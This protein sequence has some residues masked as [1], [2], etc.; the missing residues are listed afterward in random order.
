MDGTG[1]M[2]TPLRVLVLEGRAAD[3]ELAVAELRWAG[4]APEWQRVETEEDY[5]AALGPELDVILSDYSLTGFDAPRALE[6][7]Q[8]KGLD[9]PFIAV[10][11]VVDED[12]A[13]ALMREGAADYLLK[14]RL[15]RLGQAVGHALEERRLREAE[16]RTE[17]DLRA[18]DERFRRLAEHA[19]DMIYRYRVVPPRGFEYVS[20]AATAITD[21][22]AQ[23][24]Y[25]DPDLI[26]KLVHPDD[27]HL[28]EAVLAGEI[29]EKP[30]ALRW[31]RTDGAVVWTEQRDVPVRDE[32]GNLVAVEGI[33][34][35]ITE[36]VLR[37]QELRAVATMS[38]ALRVAPGRAEM[39]PVILGEVMAL[40][41]A[42]GAAL[43]LRDPESGETVVE[44]AVGEWSQMAGLRLAAG[45]GVVGHVI[46][47]GQPHI[48][49][50]LAAD[51]RHHRLPPVG[52][53][54]A[55][56][57]LPLLAQKETVGALGAGRR[58]PF[59]DHEV[60]VL[61]AIADIAASAIR[62]ATQH[63]E[64]QRRLQRLTSLHTIDLAISK[65]LNLR[66]TLHT[67]LVQVTT[68]LAVDAASVLLLDSKTQT[69]RRT[70][71]R[72]FRTRRL[73]VRSLSIPRKSFAGRAALERRIVLVPDL[74]QARGEFAHPERLAAEGFVGCAAVPL[75]TRD[76][77][78][79]VLTIYRRAPLAPDREWLGFLEALSQQAAIAIDNAQLFDE[80]QRSQAELVTAY[81]ATLEG[82]ARA[83][84]L[85]NFETAGHSNRVTELTVR[86]GRALRM[87]EA[88]LAEARRGALLHDI[89]KMAIPD[90]IL[91]K[92][93][94][95]TPDEWEIMR[96][97]PTHAFELLSPITFLRPAAEIA[98]SHHEKWDGTGYP[99]GLKGEE[100]PLGA[101]AF[102]VCDV[103]DA[104]L[105]ERPYK[106]AWSPGDA[107][108]QIR[109]LTGSHFDPRV[110]EAFLE[111]D[112]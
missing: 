44:L 23:E 100:I 76:V 79:G 102:A 68:R 4:Y 109:S 11:G 95:L 78:V 88:E 46:A 111:L 8:A 90:A 38:R 56:V 9:V 89:G 55:A 31:L 41:Q 66:V 99:R 60:R 64:T 96:R 51:A 20:P 70:A 42:D 84:E 65:S 3:A 35:D 57:T 52:E 105:S 22:T 91:L 43:S 7:L 1:T 74:T 24:H 86:L 107:R 26:L 103:W 39:A 18:G 27:R 16:R 98:Y 48:T 30:V 59:A 72:G 40:L 81:D 32:A 85:R 83:L 28:L 45:A 69:L 112:L 14:D 54:R 61:E 29:S 75:V 2:N 12:R 13:V 106:R 5:L 94:P 21:H 37:D 63:E 92:P 77:V 73:K 47:T 101:R 80:A 50:D 108:E 33:A 15:T 87:D 34:R 93:G 110:V 71:G 6:L 49:G 19:P 53:A 97:H 82:W 10:S 25:S 104:L 67:L 58:T 62:R 36:R 17:A